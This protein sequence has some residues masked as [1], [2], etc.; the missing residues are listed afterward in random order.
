MLLTES[1]LV[2]VHL[3]VV[4]GFQDWVVEV[5]LVDLER[6]RQA[7]LR[8]QYLQVQLMELFRVLELFQVLEPNQQRQQWER[9]GRV[10]GTIRPIRYWMIC[11]SSYLRKTQKTK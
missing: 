7:E 11:L 9:V 4:V 8:E 1:N 10:G 2:E 3:V 5:G 6:N